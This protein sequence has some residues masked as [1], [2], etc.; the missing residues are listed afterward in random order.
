M[1]KSYSKYYS[2]IIFIFLGFCIADIL[3]LAFRDRM[4]PQGAP[5][6]KPAKSYIENSVGRGVYNTIIARNIFSSSGVI[7]E[8]L[9]DKL[10]S[11]EDKEKEAPPILSQLPI[12]LIGTL[13]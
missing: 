1:A 2:L 7:P 3:I 10:K 13:V 5:P 9:S 11:P 4:L 6:A 12:S 8:A